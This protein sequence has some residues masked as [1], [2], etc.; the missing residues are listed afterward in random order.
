[1]CLVFL[2][3][4]YLTLQGK[5]HYYYNNSITMTQQKTLSKPQKKMMTD[6]EKKRRRYML[7]HIK[8]SGV[9]NFIQ[10]VCKNACFCG[11][12]SKELYQEF[13]EKIKKDKNIRGFMYSY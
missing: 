11:M 12:T 5:E 4:I 1:M 9:D 8:E 3:F 2:V 10:D 7:K 6:Q 13:I